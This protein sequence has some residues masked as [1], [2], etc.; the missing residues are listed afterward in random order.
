MKSRLLIW[1]ICTGIVG[2]DCVQYIFITDTYRT[3]REQFDM[4]F[5]NL[6][7]DGMIA[8]NNLDLQ[9]GFDSVL[10]L[11]DN[12]ALEFSLFPSGYP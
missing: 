12:M 2:A 10:F 3:K 11:L 6:V 8:F 9:F 4:Q 1:I 5:G 7:K